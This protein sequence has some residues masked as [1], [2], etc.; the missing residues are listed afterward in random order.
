MAKVF[1]DDSG[2]SAEEPVMWVAGW[3]GQ[4]QTWDDFAN[5]WEKTLAAN[6]PKPIKYFKHYEARSLSK[7][8]AGF[9]ESEAST[10]MINLAETI[11]K[12]RVYGVIYCVGRAYLRAMIKK[13]AVEPVHQNL[14]DPFFI[15]I[16]SLT[17]YVLGSESVGYPNDKVDFIFDGKP[18]SAQANRLASMF[19]VTRE[20][21]PDPIPKLM[22]S[23]IPM[24]DK[25]VLPLQ[26]ADLLAGQARMSHRQRNLGDPEPLS[27]LRRRLPMWIKVVDEQ[28][29]LS[30]ISFHNFGI[31]T[32]R[33]LAI[34]RE[35]D[36]KKKKESYKED[37]RPV[38]A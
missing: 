16:N 37:T 34:S 28:T 32:R 21:G 8:F 23:A 5:D 38:K 26:A 13:H 24:N 4:V 36:R 6:N 10:K 17:G 7:C 1:V 29:I 27:L 30:T 2:R 25:E 14:K 11:T 18:G 9:S 12:Y 31:S 3:V 22:G 19:E 20:F 35:R 33:L 15:C